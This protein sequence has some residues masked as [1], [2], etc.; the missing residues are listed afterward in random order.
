MILVM[1]RAKLGIHIETC[2]VKG[3]STPASYNVQGAVLFLLNHSKH[4]H[5]CWKSQEESLKISW[6]HRPAHAL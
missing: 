1:K 3:C 4:R 6:T 5:L 2:S